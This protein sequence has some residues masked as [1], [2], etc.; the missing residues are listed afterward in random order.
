MSWNNPKTESCKAIELTNRVIPLIPN[1]NGGRD[2]VSENEE[3]K[4]NEERV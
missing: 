1:T 2:K 4:K 3:K